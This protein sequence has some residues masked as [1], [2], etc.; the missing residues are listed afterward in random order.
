MEGDFFRGFA[1]FDVVPPPPTVTSLWGE[2]EALRFK[3]VRLSLEVV[4]RRL[5]A[6]LLTAAPALLPLSLGVQGGVMRKGEGCC[7]LQGSTV[8]GDAGLLELVR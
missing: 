8:V 2:Q 5:R 4:L 3:R 6:E 7:L 1:G